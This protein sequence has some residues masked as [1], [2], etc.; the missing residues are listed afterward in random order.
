M[1]SRSVTVAGL[2]PIAFCS[3]KVSLGS[4]ERRKARN[5]DESGS[6][7][8]PDRGQASA[9]K[10]AE[11]DAPATHKSPLLYIDRYV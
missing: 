6:D 1:F 7:S 2:L 8:D 10:A 9:G 3:D 5:K 11:A 4:S